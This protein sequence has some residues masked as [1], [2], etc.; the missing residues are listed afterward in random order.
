MVIPA[1]NFQI[2]RSLSLVGR[3]FFELYSGSK[4]DPYNE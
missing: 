3:D 2:R 1:A 4:T